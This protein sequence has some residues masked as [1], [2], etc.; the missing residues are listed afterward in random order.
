[1]SVESPTPLA[2]KLGI[3]SGS[4]LITLTMPH[5]LVLEL[6]PGV[7]VRTRLAG[8]ADVILAFARRTR[9]VEDRMERLAAAIF[10][11]GGLWIAW[12]KQASKVPTDLSD[13]AVRDLAL[14]HGLVDNKVCAINETWSA[15]RVVW[16]LEHRSKRPVQS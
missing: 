8:R 11:A 10:P 2:N 13:H 6:P 9:D 12:P 4:V 3:V 5:D 16:R 1:M 15:L 14:P 7:T